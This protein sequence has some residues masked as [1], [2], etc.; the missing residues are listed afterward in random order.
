MVYNYQY[1]FYFDDFNHDRVYFD[2]NQDEAWDQDDEGEYIHES[3]DRYDNC[4]NRYSY[5]Y[6]CNNTF[7]RGFWYT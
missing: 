4:I 3:F 7:P 1:F 2:R 6:S 5:P